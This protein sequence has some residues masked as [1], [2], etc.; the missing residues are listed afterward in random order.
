MWCARPYFT[1]FALPPPRFG[2]PPHLWLV[3]FVFLLGF[4][5]FLVFCFWGRK[6]GLEGVWPGL[7]IGWAYLVLWGA[8]LLSAPWSRSFDVSSPFLGLAL[9]FF[10][11]QGFAQPFTTGGGGF[12][13]VPPTPTPP[14][15][16]GV[17]NPTFGIPFGLKGPGLCRT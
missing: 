11:L 12:L 4:F 13:G 16:S 1:P 17:Q 8:F 3:V 5:L 6:G 10:F 2:L 7:L 9:F 15:R 14:P